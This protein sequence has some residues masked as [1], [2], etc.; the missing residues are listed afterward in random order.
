MPASG[1][2]QPASGA[3]DTAR[4]SNDPLHPDRDA[5]LAAWAQRVRANREQVERTRESAPAA[6]FYAPFAPRF[7]ADPR[8]TDDAALD[9]LRSL[10][11][12][13]ETWMDIG[14]G[15]GRYA[16][17][18]ALR[19]KEVIAV[20]PSEGMIGVLREGM[21]EYGIQNIRIV[22]STWPMD[23]APE[24]DVCLIS[25]V[26]YDIEQIGP[27]LDGMEASARRLCVAVLLDRAPASA[28][29]PF[30]EAVHGEP[31][32]ELP[33]LREFLALQLARGR[34][35]E[36]RLS[37][38]DMQ[39]FDSPEA[40]LDFLRM[41]LFIEPGGEKEQ[42][43]RAA[44]SEALVPVDGRFALSTEPMALGVVTWQPPG[45]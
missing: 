20:E 14:A 31:R 28:A 29:S 38:R 24:A 17:P 7:R 19:A 8:R 32:A 2:L 22:P 34:L 23:G 37:G 5:A 16:L 30:W 33:A 41:Q 9:V 10:I 44:L 1:F 43:L 18:I 15:G 27:F 11:D 36:V 42:R 3:G 45:E 12:R 6:D 40:P 26:G 13:D 21:A 35:C 39:T 25:H 4:M